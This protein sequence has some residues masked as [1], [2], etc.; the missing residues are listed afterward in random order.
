MTLW[1]PPIVVLAVA[2]LQRGV[3]LLL[4]KMAILVTTVCLLILSIPV[5]SALRAN[6]AYEPPGFSG[7]A[8]IV[9]RLG[10]T[11][12]PGNIM[13]FGPHRQLFVFFVRTFDH[14][15]NTYV[16]QGEDITA[17]GLSLK[18]ACRDFRVRHLLV[19]EA[20]SET[21]SGRRIVEQLADSDVFEQVSKSTFSRDQKDYMIVSFRYTLPISEHMKPIRLR[22]PL[23][24]H[25]DRTVDTD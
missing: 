9:E 20:I 19:E 8:P 10:M 21:E 22:S 24:E 2:A 17:D 18:Q 7:I 4:R 12:D 13:F 11:N 5:V 1:Y 23:S 16:L 6:I 3:G 14:E 25:L 15:R